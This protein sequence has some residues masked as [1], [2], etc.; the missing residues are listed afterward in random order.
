MGSTFIEVGKPLTQ[1]VAF[2][3]N[4]DSSRTA[5]Q[6]QVGNSAPDFRMGFVNDLTYK[7]LNF[8]FVLDWHAGRQRHRPHHV[9]LRR[10]RRT[11]RLRARTE[12]GDRFNRCYAAGV[13]TCY[14]GDATFL[15]LREVD[16]RGIALP[17]EA[18]STVDRAGARTRSG[19]SVTGR[20]LVTL[21]NYT[22]LDPE[23]A[24]IGAAAI[25]NNLDV[26]QYPPSRSVFF[27]IAVGF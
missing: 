13:M 4:P 3:F 11:R 24:N 20:N 16:L 18:G 8:S 26:A 15:K 10:R 6:V 9:P 2:G 12:L 23:V 7:S 17:Q 1:I 25:R 21:T 5:T 14:M 22:G 27:N 19:V